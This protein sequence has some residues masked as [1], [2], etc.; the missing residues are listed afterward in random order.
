VNHFVAQA[1]AK[2]SLKGGESTRGLGWFLTNVQDKVYKRGVACNSHKN[3]KKGD[4][5]KGELG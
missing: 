1:I 3:R 5:P 4:R 2:M